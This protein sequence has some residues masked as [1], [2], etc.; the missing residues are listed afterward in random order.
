M[1]ALSELPGLEIHEMDDGSAV[2][3]DPNHE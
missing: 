2:A 1:P 3:G